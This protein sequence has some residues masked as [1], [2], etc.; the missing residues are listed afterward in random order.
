MKILLLLALIAPC[1]AGEKSQ[2]FTQLDAGKKQVIVTYGTSLTAQGAWV[3][4]M[5]S[6]LDQR[7]PKQV[8]VINKGGSGKHSGWGVANLEQRVLK[9]RPD[10]VF[11]EFS[12]NDSVERFDISVEIA[13]S[14]LE[15]MLDAI[16]KMNPICEIIL[17]TMTPGDVYPKG[18]RSH[19]KDLE[20][21]YEM[22]RAVA[23]KRNLQ[24]IDHAPNWKALQSS[25]ETLF[26]KYVPDTIHPTPQGCSKIITPV[27]L[28]A[29]GIETVKDEKL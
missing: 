21:H 6:A 25:D 3:K 11:I 13:Q 18:H 5:Q 20:T 10:T 7:F 23:K 15:T 27:I 28:N 8:T 9:F 1:L 29:L 22:Y 12:I 17:M 24:I 26:K 4:Q 14:N 16:L 19:R 2:L